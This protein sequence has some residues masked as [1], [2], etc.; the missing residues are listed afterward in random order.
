MDVIMS[1][2]KC[3]FMGKVTAGVTH[4]MKNVLAIIKESAGLMQDLLEV[5][6]EDKLKNKFI[7]V[8]SNIEQQ[9]ARGVDI[10]TRLNAFAHSPDKKESEIILREAAKELVFFS[11]RRARLKG[12]ALNLTQSDSSAVIVANSLLFH[13]ILHEALDLIMDMVDDNSTI[14]ISVT[15][16]PEIGRAVNL[17]VEVEVA[18]LEEKLATSEF[19][20][21]W[22]DLQ[23][24]AYSEGITLKK[25]A[26]PALI[27]CG[28]NR[29]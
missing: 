7:R 14:S 25:A 4:E 8:L 29:K 16:D 17:A 13:M 20:S 3:V 21:R 10:S 5:S 26:P 6:P 2:D 15:E 9:V 11:Q 1:M 19:E 23:Q 12:I 22:G 18:G 28:L 24:Y 27:V